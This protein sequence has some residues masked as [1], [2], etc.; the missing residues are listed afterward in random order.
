MGFFDEIFGTS[1]LQR[2]VQ[3]YFDG[4]VSNYEAFRRCMYNMIAVRMKTHE[5]NADYMGK[6]RDEL[7]V[8]NGDQAMR[9][10]FVVAMQRIA[11]S[12]ARPQAVNFMRLNGRPVL[13]VDSEATHH[14]PSGMLRFDLLVNDRI[15]YAWA[16]LYDD[17]TRMSRTIPGAEGAGWKI[18]LSG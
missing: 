11:A 9:D 4:T 8:Q 2:E 16:A 15:G 17:G 5:L 1:D 14:K 3:R 18:G 12:A 13:W 10:F 6:I 7:F